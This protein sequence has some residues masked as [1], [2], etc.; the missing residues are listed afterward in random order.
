[1]YYCRMKTSEE[2]DSHSCSC[3]PQNISPEIS[4]RQKFW[5]RP[6]MREILQ[7]ECKFSI[8][9]CFQKILK[10][11]ANLKR[12]GIFIFINF[13]FFSAGTTH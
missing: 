13:R 8:K 2:V 6:C 1:M 9:Y 3:I 5:L 4:L 10:V 12:K 7:A 11:P